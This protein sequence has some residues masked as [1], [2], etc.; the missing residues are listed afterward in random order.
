MSEPTR[1]MGH[2][3]GVGHGTGA[4]DIGKGHGQ[5]VNS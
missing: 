4:W 1:G 2:W 3:Q 5:G